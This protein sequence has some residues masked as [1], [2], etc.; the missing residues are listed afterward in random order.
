MEVSDT[1][2]KEMRCNNGYCPMN[3]Q[4]ETYSTDSEKYELVEKQFDVSE[5][6]DEHPFWC[7]SFFMR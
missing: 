2:A 6:C 1:N 5:E 3:K 4:C 7:E